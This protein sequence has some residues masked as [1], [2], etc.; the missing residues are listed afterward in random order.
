MMRINN[1]TYVKAL[2]ALWKLLYESNINTNDPYWQSA[3][4]S[5]EL[6]WCLCSKNIISKHKTFIPESFKIPIH[7]ITNNGF[8]LCYCC[9][10]VT[11]WCPT[12]W[13][14]MNCS[15]PSIPVLHYLPEFAQTRVHWVG[16]AIQQS[17]PLSP[18]SPPAF[19]LSLYQGLLEWVS[20][21]HQVA[22]VFELQHQSLQWIVKSWHP[23]GLTALI[24]LQSKGLSRVFS[25]TTT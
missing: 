3:S 25:S 11:K 19:T 6:H 2:W 23:L 17:H 18:P 10:S 5:T 16:D 4:F 12:L 22:K 1:L 24:F 20:C 13:D 21:S 7:R 8:F 15:T 14:P 9:C